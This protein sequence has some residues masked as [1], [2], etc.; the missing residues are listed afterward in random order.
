ME[1]GDGVKVYTYTRRELFN[2]IREKKTAQGEIDLSDN[3]LIP[4][5][6]LLVR[7]NSLPGMKLNAFR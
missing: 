5:L 4:T 2:K 3:A 1:D 6:S 7:S